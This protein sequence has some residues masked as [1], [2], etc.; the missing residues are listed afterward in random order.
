M[1]ATQEEQEELDDLSNLFLNSLPISSI[2]VLSAIE[3]FGEDIDDG[4]EDLFKSGML[5]EDVQKYPIQFELI[6]RLKD[7]SQENPPDRILLQ[8]Y[9]RKTGFRPT[10]EFSDLGEKCMAVCVKGYQVISFQGKETI[11]SEEQLSPL[12]K[13]EEQSRPYVPKNRTRVNLGDH[14]TIKPRD[15]LGILTWL[16][17]DD[18]VRST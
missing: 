5:Q 12:Y 14:Y 15:Y 11:I 10:K 17:W 4:S 13:L 2:A 9:K 7:M 3:L 6:T 8:V 18:V 1:A 16:F